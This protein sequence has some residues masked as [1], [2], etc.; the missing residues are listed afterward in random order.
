MLV[1]LA[2]RRFGFGLES[3]KS[4]TLLINFRMTL[5]SRLEVIRAY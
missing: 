3:D 2:F 4:E 1:L 5:L